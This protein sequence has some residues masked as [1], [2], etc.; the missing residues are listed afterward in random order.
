VP[1]AS[2][3]CTQGLQAF[4]FLLLSDYLMGMSHIC[5]KG[6]NATAVTLF[7]AFFALLQCE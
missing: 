2:N 5:A 6:L 4:L 7:G 1:C 3:A